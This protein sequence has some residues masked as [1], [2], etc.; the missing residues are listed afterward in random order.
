[1][2]SSKVFYG[3][4]IVAASMLA[5]STGIAPFVYGSFGLFMIPLG[6]EFGW[7]RTELSVSLSF[8]LFTS[9]LCMPVV[10]RLVDQFGIRRVLMPS[11][12]LLGLCLL[13]IPAYVSAL[14]HLSLVL[15]LAGTL[16]AAN[17]T[18]SFMPVLSAWFDRRRGLA[19]GIAVAGIGLG[20]FYVPVLVQ[21]AIEG[22]G[23]RAGY[24]LLAAILLGIALPLVYLIIKESPA[25]LGLGPD[26]VGETEPQRSASTDVGLSSREIFKTREFW[27]LA[28][29]F[30]VLSFVLY[31]SLAH[32]VPMLLDRGMRAT[33]AAGVQ[34]LLGVSVLVARILIGFLV[35]RYFA[36]KVALVAFAASAVGIGIFALGAAGPMAYVA[37]MMIGLSIG[38][39]VDLLAYM[40][41][42][43]F[44]LRAFGT[45]CGLLLGA[46]VCGSVFGPPIFGQG[47]ESTGSYVGVLTMG[48]VVNLI[49]LAMTATLGPYPDWEAEPAVT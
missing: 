14:W 37:A 13:A 49:V 32:L 20:Y 38:A 4:W 25:E 35:D 39:E 1:M 31:G 27:T 47:Y 34:S 17:N 5:I 21:F 11:M 30:C 9:A 10:G 43:Y 3:W 45:T 24:Y 28:A 8:L 22:Y 46:I 6:E 16:G 48:V 15:A 40:S 19:L 7:N 18:V 26:G 41:S 29:I 23:W 42:R 12:I 44:G 33:Q 2:N 36:P